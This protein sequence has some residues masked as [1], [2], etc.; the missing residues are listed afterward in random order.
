MDRE[1]TP[2][3]A[4]VLSGA[5]LGAVQKAITSKAI[6]ARVKRGRRLLKE[7]GVYAL[8]IATSVPAS[9][10]IPFDHLNGAVCAALS[11]SRA[12]PVALDERGVWTFDADKVIGDVRARVRL[13]DRARSELIT[14]NP[15]VL[16]GTPAIRDT[17]LSVYAI[18]GR[19]EAGETVDELRAEYPY[20]TREQIEAAQIYANANPL[21]GRPVAQAWKRT[22]RKP[23]RSS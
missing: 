19:L 17:R 5:K 14:S 12:G 8:A 18:A 3:E 6:R 4:A 21:R 13:Y 20:V 9:W 2:Q 22:G 16:G 15:N 10:R 1:Y 23:T 7:D 11:D